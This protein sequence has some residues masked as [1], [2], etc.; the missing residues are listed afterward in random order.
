MHTLWHDWL[1]KYEG[2]PQ[3]DVCAMFQKRDGGSYDHETLGSHGGH[4]LDPATVDG[5]RSLY[6]VELLL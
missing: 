3:K 1:K 4:R 5:L 2:L 6:E